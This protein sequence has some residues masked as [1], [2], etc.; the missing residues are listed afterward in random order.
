MNTPTRLAQPSFNPT[1]AHAAARAALGIAADG[2][3]RGAEREPL[4][5]SRWRD[6]LALLQRSVAFTRQVVHA[7]D[8]IYHG[9][10]PFAALYVINAGQFKTVN[11]SDDGRDQ[12]VGLHFKGDWLGFDGIDS[13]HYGCD[14]IALDTAEVWSIR[15]ATLLEACATSNELMRTVH[16]AMSGQIARE[17]QSMLSL[18]TLPAHARVA[19]FLLDW[20]ESLAAR[21]LR[22][23]QISLH[24]SRAEIGNFLGL[25]LETV[26]RAL[27]RLARS[28]VIR[29]DEKGRRNIAIPQ[30]QA[31]RDVI[32]ESIDDAGGATKLPPSR[33]TTLVPAP[34]VYRAC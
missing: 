9:G 8:V 29:F 6:G 18:G 30:V 2:Q 24:M 12:V 15:Y 19:K 23:D 28:G 4:R 13:G 31:L 14:A 1:H 22:T 25:T 27:S 21:D 11:I 34:R 20:T 10:Q 32:R 17:C 3:A 7:G 16:A 5:A 26:S 33:S